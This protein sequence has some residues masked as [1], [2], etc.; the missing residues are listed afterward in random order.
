MFYTWGQSAAGN[1]FDPGFGKQVQWD[2]PLLEGYAHEFLTNTSGQPGTHHRQG[3]I[4]PDAVARI[5]R[6]NPQAVLVFGWAYTSHLKIIRHFKNKLPVL[7]RGDSTLLDERPGWKAVARY[8]FLR[9]VYKHIDKALYVGKNNYAYFRKF[10]LRPVQL[11]WAPHAVDND[12]FMGN[13][14]AYRQEALVRRIRL[15][16]RETDFVFLFAG[17]LEPKKDPFLLLEA[18][19]T[20]GFNDVVHL[21]FAG[22]GI[23][24]EALKANAASDVRIH[25]LD[26]QNQQAMPALYRLADVYVLPSKG[27]EETWGLAVNEAMACGRA[28][29]VSNKCGCAPDLVEDAVN[30]YVFTAGDA[31]ALASKMHLLYQGQIQATVDAGSFPQKNQAVF[32]GSSLPCGRDPCM[33]T[34]G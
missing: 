12:R 29:I 32:A 30:G 31:K 9:W 19:M 6:F 3:I 24:E 17:K 1:Q 22:N 21:V 33:F 20:A 14:A 5:Q 4:N 7:F 26:F 13:D 2:I 27:P 8:W 11:V 10:G 28:V 23:L 34:V 15:H 25:F 16:I 18:F